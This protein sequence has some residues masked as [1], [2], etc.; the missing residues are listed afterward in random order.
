MLFKI[1]PYLFHPILQQLA[2]TLFLNLDFIL[3]KEFHN[4]LLQDKYL[5]KT[6]I[7]YFLQMFKF[8]YLI[9]FYLLLIQITL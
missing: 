1:Y 5:N 3:F 2:Q 9:R 4:N 6:N 7:K 8:K